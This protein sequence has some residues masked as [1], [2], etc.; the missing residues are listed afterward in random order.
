LPTW[1]ATAITLPGKLCYN[2]ALLITSGCLFPLAAIPFPTIPKEAVMLPIGSGQ[3]E[4]WKGDTLLCKVDY[5]ISPPLPFATETQH[6]KLVVHDY[7][8]EQLLAVAGLTLVLADG[9]RH[10]LPK[11]LDLVSG[12]GRL[13]CFWSADM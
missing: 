6:V 8:C 12:D 2:K 11:P 9:S 3:G 1:P 5:D 13:E 10:R 4:L 7:D